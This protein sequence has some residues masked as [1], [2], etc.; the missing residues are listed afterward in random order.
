M[1]IFAK[2]RQEA[3]L[4]F[5]SLD[6]LQNPLEEAARLVGEGLTAG[7]KLLVCGNGG[8]AADGADFATEFACRFVTDRQ[9]FPALNLTAC[10]SL[11]TAIANDY[12]YEQTFARQVSAFGKRGDVL[13]GITTSG[14]SANV[15]A[16][17][18]VS[19]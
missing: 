4:T 1:T 18:R 2:A 17:L 6:A 9:P 3:L 15:L 7:A 14:N 10:G 19:R 13:V 12:G 8:S 5:Q 16:A 11:V